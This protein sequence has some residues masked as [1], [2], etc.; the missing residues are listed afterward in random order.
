MARRR[1]RPINPLAPLTPAQ[2]RAQASA[3][4]AALLLPSRQEV[5]RTRKRVQQ[6]AADQARRAEG[7]SRALA[8]LQRG[9]GPATNQAYQGAAQTQ[10]ALAQGFTGAMRSS[11]EADANAAAATLSRLGA[12]SSQISQVQGVGQGAADQAYALGGYIP[13]QSLAREGAAFSAA[14][15]QLP[16]TT[17]GRGQ[18]QI[19]AIEKARRDRE[20]ELDDNLRELTDKAPGLRS[21]IIDRLL[22]NEQAKT[23]TQ[24][25][26]EYLNVNRGN[27]AEDNLR[28]WI[29]LMGYDPRT[30]EPTAAT[31]KGQADAAAKQQGVRSKSVKAR[32]DAF[33]ATRGEAFGRARQLY[34]GEEE[35]NPDWW[36]DPTKPR[37]IV[38]RPKYQEAYQALWDEFGPPLLRYASGSG[39]ASLKKRIQR[40]I[41]LALRTAGFKPA[42]GKPKAKRSKNRGPGDDRPG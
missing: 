4:L 41:N 20:R 36:N 5:A 12:P 40:I 23:A 14:Q 27:T 42:A 35:D 10:G 39:K 29:E 32:E 37:K 17:L 22:Q 13:G 31:R 33:T 8:E 30:G 9:I 7:L 28:D 25:Q 6:E 38:K 2:L 26:A 18:Q 24:I 3:E 11:A 19:G 1:N 34:K 21:Q 15:N 16:A